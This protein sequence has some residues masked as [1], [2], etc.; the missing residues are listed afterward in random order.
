MVDTAVREL[1]GGSLHQAWSRVFAENDN[2]TKRLGI[3]INCNNSFDRNDGAGDVIDALP[4]P[5]I[6]VIRGFLLAGGTEE[7]VAVFDQTDDSKPRYVAS[8]FRAK[9]RAHF[10]RVGFNTF[11]YGG[12][13]EAQDA[14]SA[15]THVTWSP[16]YSPAPPETKLK[17]VP[18]NADY[19]VNVPIV[20]RH[21]QANVTLG[22]KNHFG[23]ITRPG[24][25]HRYVYEDVT[26]ASVLVDIMN[27]PRVPGDPSVRTL[28]DKTV[29]TVGDL[30]YGHACTNFGQS[31]RPWKQ[32]SGEWPNSLLISDDPVAADSVMADILEAEP[33]PGGGCGAIRPWARRHLQIAQY[34]GHGVFDHV[35]LPA[36]AAFDPARMLYTKLDYRYLELSPSGARLTVRRE[37]T[38]SAHLTWQHY[39]PGEFLVQR[40]SRADF[41]DAQTIARTSASSY[42]D[43]HAPAGAYYRVLFES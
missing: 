34:A 1:K 8:W 3:K 39:F 6:A 38:S 28:A 36:G 9:V 7:R 37:G 17:G 23:S 20:K 16:G 4:E 13:S 41:G 27:S 31:P 24:N 5:V 15:R 26:H 22:Y 33:L 19:L 40:A 14:W 32:W 21:N 2:A 18:L 42:T 30:L 35:A 25:L 43:K 10:P 12:A 29:L 11:P